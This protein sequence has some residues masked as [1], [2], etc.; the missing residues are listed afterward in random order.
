VAKV[1][2]T[3]T[4]WQKETENEMTNKFKE[5]GQKQRERKKMRSEVRIKWRPSI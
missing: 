5:R 1:E 4:I 2:L 3:E